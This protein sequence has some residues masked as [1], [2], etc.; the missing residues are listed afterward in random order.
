MRQAPA[1]MQTCA[2]PTDVQAACALKQKSSFFKGAFLSNH[3][4]F[5]LYNTWVLGASHV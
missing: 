2:A 3:Q 5:G 1:P 4:S